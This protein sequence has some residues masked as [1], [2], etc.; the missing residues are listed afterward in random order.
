MRLR[1]KVTRRELRTMKPWP[2][3]SSPAISMC[4]LATTV[5]AVSGEWMRK[6]RRRRYEDS[7]MATPP[8]RSTRSPGAG[9]SVTQARRSTEVSATS[10]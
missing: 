3:T 8:V 5:E 10:S 9:A 2:D 6:P 7:S 4:L 1:A